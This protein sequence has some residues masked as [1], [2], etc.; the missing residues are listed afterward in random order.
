MNLSYFIQ[1]LFIIPL[2]GFLCSLFV[3]SKNEKFISKISTYTIGFHLLTLVVLILYWIFYHQPSLNIEEIILYSKDG[4]KFVIDFYFDKVS[5]VFLIV[6]AILSF[7]VVIY[8]RYYLHRERDYK[9]FFNIILLFYLGYNLL[10]LAGNFET[11]FIGWEILG[12]SSFLLIAYY[13]D[14][15][16]PVKNAIKVFSIY[17]LGDIGILLAMWMSHF[18]WHENVS[19]LKL[20]NNELV[21]EHLISHSSM[22][23]FISV[24]LVIAA[25]IKSA[26]FPFSSWLPRAMEGPTT[27]SAIFYGSLS[28]HMGAF[29]LLRT[30]PF[31][32]NQY[33]IRILV[34]NVGLFTMLISTG[35]SRVQSTIKS[36]VAYSSIAQI[37]IIFME[38]AMGFENLALFHFAG[39][40]FLRT[41]QLLVSPSVVSYLIKEQFYTYSEA[42]KSIEYSLPKS[43]HYT[44]Y[45]LCLKEW[46]LDAF[47]YEVIWNPIKRLA[48]RYKFVDN[49]FSISIL[50][51]IFTGGIY[52][53]FN[54][55][56]LHSPLIPYLPVVFAAIGCLLM[57]KSFSEKKRVY[58]AWFLVILGHLWTTLA[59]AINDIVPLEQVVINLSGVLLSGFIGGLVLVYI[60]K[61]EKN[62]NLAFFQGHSFEYPKLDLIFLLACLGMTGFPITPMFLGEDLLFSH[63]YESQFI[64]A[65]IVSLSFI[66]DGLTVIRI[67]ARIFMGPHIKNYHPVAARNA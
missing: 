17:R 6:G 3:G 28:V 57:L 50:T 4:Y 30:H 37:G 46:N 31:W 51:I 18:L 33:A 39:N 32:E 47:I 40:A 27:S 11:L 65:T 63:I 35:I 12:I 43:F 60:S 61:K 19:F 13:R 21:S 59:I 53:Y 7:M 49:V 23:M 9:R 41:Y 15:F 44:L 48:R 25:S 45:I 62:I 20:H 55:S 42:K 56:N 29:L 58:Y 64:L 2:L 1:M 26:Q 52:V 22:G 38:I 5:V 8:S 14:R 67:Y 36:Q 24:M 66:V 10:V 34:L 16:L 54:K